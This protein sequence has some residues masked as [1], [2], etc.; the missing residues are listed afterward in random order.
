MQDKINIKAPQTNTTPSP[1]NFYKEELSR[2]EIDPVYTPQIVVKGGNGTH[3]KNLQLNPESAME[4]IHWLT[5][6]F[7]K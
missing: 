1:Y 5:Q 3:T 6:N 7:L 4:L 2:V